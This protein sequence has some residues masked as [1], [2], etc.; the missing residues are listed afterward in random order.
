VQRGNLS[1]AKGARYTA[2]AN[3]EAALTHFDDHPAAIVGLSNILLDVYSE[4]LQPPPEVPELV[5]P[6][7]STTTFVTQLDTTALAVKSTTS[8]STDKSSPRTQKGPI[9]I[10]NETRLQD[11][12]ILNLHPSL[13]Q[14]VASTTLIDR[15]AAR[16][17][18]YGLL[19]GLT[20]LGSG[21]NDSEAWFALARAYEEGDQ[22]DKAREVL[23][24]CIELEEGK[25]V[26]D[27]HCVG[28]GGYVL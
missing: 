26:R 24:W 12:Q 27:W 4:E 25:G 23:W 8:T 14:K 15:I 9:G 20:K 10:S 11:P 1:S 13:P 6:T 22:L 7:S 18:A 5:V 2:L 21:W 3:F 17:R 28:L 16:D 19:S